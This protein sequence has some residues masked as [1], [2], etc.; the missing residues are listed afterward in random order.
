[1]LPE[2]QKNCPIA[3]HKNKFVLLTWLHEFIDHLESNI[4][5]VI[6][7]TGYHSHTRH[8]RFQWSIRNPHAITF[9][10]NTLG[11]T[12]G[13]SSRAVSRAQLDH[14][15]TSVRF[16]MR[17][18]GLPTNSTSHGMALKRKDVIP[19]HFALLLLNSAGDR[20]WISQLT[21]V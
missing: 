7:P 6:G 5:T 17:R 1:M 4:I 13:P 16:D 15:T 8:E 10:I 19:R 12:G 21:C 2:L 20:G 18:R 9:S 14:H 11:S 3:S